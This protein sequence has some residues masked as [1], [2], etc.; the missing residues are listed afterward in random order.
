MKVLSSGNLAEINRLVSFWIFLTHALI[1]LFSGLAL[2]LLSPP[3]EI[4]AL[5]LSDCLLLLQKGPDDRLQLRY[6]SRWLGGGSG[7]SKTSFSPFVKLD[8]LLVRP[9]A[10]GDHTA[11]LRQIL[12]LKC[13]TL[14]LVCF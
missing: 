3:I 14:R 12:I 1:S 2:R 9:V 10:T 5:L 13:F 8:S 4:Q 11:P 6:P 7:D